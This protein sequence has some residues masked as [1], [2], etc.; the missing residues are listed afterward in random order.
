MEQ[1]EAEVNRKEKSITN[2][3]LKSSAFTTLFS[4]PKNAASLFA[5]LNG[6]RTIGPEEIEYTTLQGVLFMVRK[7]DLAFVAGRKV[8]VI[9]EHQATI[10]ENMPLR[11]VIYYGR[12]IEKL[13]EPRA[14][15]PTNRIALPVPEFFVFYNGTREYPAEKELKLSD[16][17]LEKTDEP[18]L[19]LRVKV[20]NINLPVHHPVLEQCRPLYEYSWF[21]DQIR[22]FQQK[23]LSRDA[24]LI[25]AM[26]NCR[27]KD[28][29][30]EF[31]KEHGTE[32]VN[33]LFTEFNVEDALEVRGEEKFAEGFQTG[34]NQGKNQGILEGKQEAI[35]MLL[36][37][38]GSVS[39][40][41][42]NCIKA[43]TD[44]ILLDQWLKCA[45]RAE[46]PEE[47]E[48]FIRR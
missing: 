4:D 40:A 19:E 11:D 18:M 35:L 36:R 37:E 16:A 7:N 8:L 41:L 26:E 17:Y 10:N 22:T 46:M 28:I 43:Q 5:A 38:K 39:Q 20:I 30:T 25:E 34:I 2:R 12:T 9:S 31:L 14:L 1:K 44:P 33:M 21:I 13:I 48:R 42:E 3:E 24:A 23:G 29:L 6:N 45:V 27:K 32:A 15:Y 47:F